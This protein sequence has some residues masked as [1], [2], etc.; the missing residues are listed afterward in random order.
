M[1]L[2][3]GI[4]VDIDSAPLL[5]EAQRLLQVEQSEVWLIHVVAPEPDFV[6]YDVGPQTVR[7]ALAAE[8]HAEH[9]HLQTLAQTLRD[10]GFTATALM[11]QGATAETLL[12][13]A[14][15]LGADVLVLGSHG[16]GAMYNLVVGSVTEDVIRRT[17]IPV[18]VVPVRG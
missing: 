16:H 11:V 10:E 2:V 5:Q 6:G 9:S 13:Q 18:H 17:S 7:D 8:Y 4:D 12:A 3:V 14:D 1:K 15:K